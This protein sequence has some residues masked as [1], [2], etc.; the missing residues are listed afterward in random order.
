MIEDTIG[1]R[2]CYPYEDELL[3][4]AEYPNHGTVYYTYT[5]EGYLEQSTDQNGNTYVQ[6]YYDMDGCVTSQ[7]LSNGQEYI[8][9]FGLKKR[10]HKWWSRNKKLESATKTRYNKQKNANI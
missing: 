6:N 4:E 5:P 3:T 7:T 1:R 9:D 8:I 2:I 10:Y